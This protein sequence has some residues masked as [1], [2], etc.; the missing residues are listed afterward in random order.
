[1]IC[2]LYRFEQRHTRAEDYRDRLIRPDSPTHFE[3]IIDH[4]VMKF[5]AWYAELNLEIDTIEEQENEK[6]QR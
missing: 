4:Q 1:M 3:P 2:S 5:G 6:K